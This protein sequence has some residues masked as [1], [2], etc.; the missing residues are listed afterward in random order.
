M[1][2]TLKSH[3]IWNDGHFTYSEVPNKRAVRLLIL[4]FSQPKYVYSYLESTLI[5]LLEYTRVSNKSI[6]AA[7]NKDSTYKV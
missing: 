3:A 5:W 7:D 6:T 1:K 2:K 4:W